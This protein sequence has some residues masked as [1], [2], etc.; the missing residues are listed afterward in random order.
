MIRILIVDDSDADA[1][2]T[3]KIIERSAASVPAETWRARSRLEMRQQLAN[4]S[5]DCILLDLNL[6]DSHG[7]DTL[8]SAYQASNNTPVIVLSGSATRH[9]L[10][11]DPSPQA[12][13]LIQKKHLADA[14]DILAIVLSVIQKAA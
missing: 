9:A 8:T 2:I 13:A 11:A 4:R 1:F 6:S 12:A 10:T 14:D 7:L 5:F 3:N